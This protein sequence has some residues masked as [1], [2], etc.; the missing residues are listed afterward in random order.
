MN[1]SIICSNSNA[2][3]S[4]HKIFV[5]PR[6]YYKIISHDIRVLVCIILFDTSIAEKWRHSFGLC[7]V[8]LSR[9]NLN[10]LLIKNSLVL[11][12]YI[13]QK[14]RKSLKSRLYW[15]GACGKS[16]L[17]V[18]K[19]DTSQFIRLRT[20]NKRKYTKKL[21]LKFSEFNPTTGWKPL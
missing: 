5:E 1:F 15:C 7:S 12:I 8:F 21:V 2:F 18:S 10:F 6:I 13:L 9:K 17:C 11:L 4:K 14:S 20:D 19:Y 3:P 16:Y